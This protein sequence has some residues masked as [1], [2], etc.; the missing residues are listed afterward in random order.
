VT[1]STCNKI[2]KVLSDRD[3]REAMARGEFAGSDDDVR[4]GFI[5]LSA[6]HQLNATLEKYYRNESN[7][8]LVAFDPD[9]LGPKLKWEVSRGGDKFPH[10]YGAL[11]TAL[12][13]WSKLMTLGSDGIPLLPLEIN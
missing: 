4:D 10:L 3:W 5:H 6:A 9:A 7:L 2:Y 1:H 12:A 8:V 11:P 13:L